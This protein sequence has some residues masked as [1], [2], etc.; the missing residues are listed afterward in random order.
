MNH[1]REKI[2]WSQEIWDRIDQAVHDECERTRVAAKF[3]PMYGPVS[4]DQLTIPADTVVTVK[5]L[6]PLSVVETA[7]VDIVELSVGWNCQ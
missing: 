7:M 2:K 4:P 5:P 6:E 3:I 1:G